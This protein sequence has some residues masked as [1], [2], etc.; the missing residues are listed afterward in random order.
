M[1]KTLLFLLIA[2]L[3]CNKPRNKEIFENSEGELL[4]TKKV[5]DSAL[6]IAE[7]KLTSKITQDYKKVVLNNYIVDET[8]DIDTNSAQ[9]E[10][11][12]KKCLE[13]Y[14]ENSNLV[15]ERVINKVLKESNETLK[16]NTYVYVEI[17]ELLFQHDISSMQ[18]N[19]ALSEYQSKHW[20]SNIFKKKRNFKLKSEKFL[21]TIEDW[22][23]STVLDKKYAFERE[24][25][26]YRSLDSTKLEIN[27]IY[28]RDK[29]TFI[30]QMIE[31]NKGV[32]DSTSSDFYKTEISKI[33]D[34][35]FK[36]RITP[37][38]SSIHSLGLPL[39]RRKITIMLS[40]KYEI[41]E[42]ENQNFIDFTITNDTISGFI[43]DMCFFES[44]SVNGQPM[45]RVITKERPIDNKYRTNNEMIDAFEM[46][47]NER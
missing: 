34:T 37:Y 15:L 33:N 28:V 7:K 25:S 41:I 1:K 47:K 38:N 2:I 44:D 21:N 3:G 45:L 39:D 43:Q 8:L 12:L 42:S 16:N 26:F 31:F 29:D 11:T 30:S 4:H 17:K 6:V 18:L 27:E 14:I 40:P 13:G 20:G 22:N 35:L 46:F 32:L 23:F 10:I 19:K 9:L 5:L 24:W 36:G